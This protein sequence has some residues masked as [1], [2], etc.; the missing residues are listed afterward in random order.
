MNEAVNRIIRYAVYVCLVY[1]YRDEF[2]ELLQRLGR[3]L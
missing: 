2:V 3:A 1:I